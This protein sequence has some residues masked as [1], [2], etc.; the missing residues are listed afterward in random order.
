[1]TI[2]TLLVKLMKKKQE[3]PRL[4]TPSLLIK[5]TQKKKNLPLMMIPTAK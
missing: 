4:I 5:L 3:F 1:M 2:I